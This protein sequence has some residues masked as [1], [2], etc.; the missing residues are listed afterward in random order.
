MA[1]IHSPR[2]N[3]ILAALPN[4]EYQR[5]LPHLEL[6]S[7]PLERRVYEAGRPVSYLYFPTTAIVSLFHIMENGATAEFAIVGYEGMIGLSLF[8]GRS[9]IPSEAVVQSAGSGYRLKAD[10]L[11]KELAL[12]GKLQALA[13]QYMQVRM[14]QI[15]LTAACNRHHHVEQQLCRW[16]LLSLDRLPGNELMM[17]HERIA[18]N[19]GVRREG[20]T[21]AAG[22][23]QS[24]GLIQ[25]YRGRINVP[26]RLKLEQ[27]TCECYAAEKKE[28]DTLRS[29]INRS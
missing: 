8:M 16:L 1:S 26:D 27:R 3:H 2:Q 11:K 12:G 22:R 9:S 19:L 10:M 29:S 14:T 18:Q 25:Y 6:I 17:T 13:L 5:L 20:V 24:E 23:L 7:M 21:E 4:A 15:A 28:F